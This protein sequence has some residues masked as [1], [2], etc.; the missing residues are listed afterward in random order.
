MSRNEILFA[1]IVPL[2]S[3]TA[4]NCMLGK[5]SWAVEETPRHR[6]MGMHQFNL[7]TKLCL[8]D[9]LLII[10]LGFKVRLCMFLFGVM[11]VFFGRSPP[12]L[13]GPGV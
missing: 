4:P 2:W 13:G 5:Y 11:M 1:K 7:F 10:I 3:A 6:L 12:P 9:Y 8:P